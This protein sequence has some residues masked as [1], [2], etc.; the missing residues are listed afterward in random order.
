MKAKGKISAVVAPDDLTADEVI[1]LD[2]QD[3]PK[4]QAI[5]VSVLYDDV[6]DPIKY[7]VGETPDGT[8]KFSFPV[9]GTNP[10]VRI[11]AG[12]DDEKKL[13]KKLTFE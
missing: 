9:A 7:Q 11:F 5:S 2:L 6:E 3:L 4:K 1:D 10:V 12:K 8:V 13:L